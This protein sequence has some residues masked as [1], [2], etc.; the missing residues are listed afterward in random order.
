[1]W[2]HL[3]IKYAVALLAVIACLELR[4]ILNPFLGVNVPFITFFFGVMVAAWYGGF[5]PGILA[6]LA[7]TVVADHF[8]IAPV[9]TL[10]FNSANV[11]ALSVFVLE[12]MGI[13]VLSGA[14]HRA[15]QEAEDGSL[16]M[17]H[18]LDS[19]SEAF[20]AVD[21]DWRYTIVNRRATE[22]LD[23]PEEALLGRHVWDMFPEY[24]D[25]EISDQFHEAMRSRS[26]R[27]FEYFDAASQRW[28]ENR[29]YPHEGG[30]SV[31][32]RDVTERKHSEQQLKQWNIELEQRVQERTKTLSASQGRLRELAA[33]L[34]LTEQRERHRLATELHDSLAQMLALARIKLAQVRRRVSLS[35]AEEPL[36]RELEEILS[37]S[38]EYTRTMI[39]ELSPPVLHQ[40]GLVMGIRWLAEQMH[41]RGLTVN[42]QVEGNVPQLAEDRLTFSFQCIRELLLNVIKHAGTDTATVKLSSGL[43]GKLRMTVLDHGRGFDPATIGGSNHFGL[44]SIRERMEAMGGHLDI[45][46]IPDQGTSAMLTLPAGL[47]PGDESAPVAVASRRERSVGDPQTISGPTGKAGGLRVLLV[48]DHRL[49]RQGLASILKGYEDLLIVGEAAD[50]EEAVQRARQLRPD[51]VVMDVNMPR[52]DG[53]EATKRIRRE[54]PETVVVGLSV[55]LNSHVE[56]AM[57]DAGAAAYLTKETAAEDLHAVIH[58]VLHAKMGASATVLSPRG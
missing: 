42:V 25:T 11:V 47:P 7:S 15:K 6:A 31:F 38:L 41:R 32:F 43:E 24:N 28:I 49:V 57:R 55:N 23:R 9:G 50:G 33:Q 16:K 36:A 58:H 56:K 37:E 45:I 39:A 8:F 10:S 27:T 40:F 21:A 52:V 20:V 12:A 35:Q 4:L 30:L 3:F 22:I 2:R 1:M 44:Y 29:L 13:S 5:G 46:S 48:D 19:I 34:S 14:L 18:L 17:K 51:V 26:P 54:L 53:I